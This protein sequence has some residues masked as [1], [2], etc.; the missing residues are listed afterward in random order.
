M[1]NV[2]N[3][4]ILEEC[5]AQVKIQMFSTLEMEQFLVFTRIKVFFF[6]LNKLQSIPS[7]MYNIIQ[8][9]IALHLKVH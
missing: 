5:R 4:R 6:I 3:I 8:S 9:D 7:Q 1:E 2:E